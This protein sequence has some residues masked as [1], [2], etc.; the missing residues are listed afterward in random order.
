MISLDEK[1]EIAQHL[2][3]SHSLFRK[4]WDLGEPIFTDKVPTAAVTFNENGD[5]LEFLF[6]EK[7]WNKLTTYDKAFVMAHEM[8]HILLEH[9]FRINDENSDKEIANQAMDICVNG[10]LVNEFKFDRS[11]LKIEEII[12]GPLCWFDVIFA[13]SKKVKKNREAEY[14]YNILKKLKKANHNTAKGNV[15]DSHLT[16]EQ[17]SAILGNIIDNIKNEISGCPI[18]EDVVDGFSEN[19]ENKAI[20]DIIIAGKSS[21]EWQALTERKINFSRKWNSIIKKRDI[22]RKITDMVEVESFIKRNK[23]FEYVFD[24]DTLIP[25]D[26]IIETEFLDKTKIGLFMFLDT[27]GSCIPF[28]ED[29]YDAYKSINKRIF[30]VR[31]FSFDTQVKELDIKNSKIHGGGGTNFQIIENKIQKIIKDEQLKTYPFVFVLTDGYGTSVN[32]ANPKNWSWFLT[33]VASSAFIPPSSK[34]FKIND[35]IK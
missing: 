2:D 26:V 29:F 14:Y 10:L 8:L 5:F 4:F 6:N 11:K 19:K 17:T 18:I 21:G 28:M 31:I 12:G 7:F 23:R 1:I 13:N 25:T 32:P 33:P 35:F 15:L 34:H 30:D 3:A 20:S 16:K 24:N 9:G 22:I 27:S